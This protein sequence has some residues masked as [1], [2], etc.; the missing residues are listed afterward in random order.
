MSNFRGGEVPGQHIE[1]LPWEEAA[2]RVVV[3]EQWAWKCRGCGRVWAFESESATEFSARNCCYTDKG[4]D[5]C[6]GRRGRHRGVCENCW[7]QK[8]VK[9]YDGLEQVHVPCVDPDH[10]LTTLDGDTYFFDEES[11]FEHC[12]DVGIKPSDMMLVHCKPHDPPRFDIRE[13][14]GDYLGED[15]DPPFTNEESSRVSDAVNALID[16]YSPFSWCPDHKKRP[17]D[18]DLK[19]LD[20]EFGSDSGGSG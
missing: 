1:K 4:C 18:A 10:P 14:V 8:Q 20:Q 15:A 13:W 19:R 11:L 9:R 3:P 2:E 17:T 7:H 12:Q 6:G 5:E 16:K